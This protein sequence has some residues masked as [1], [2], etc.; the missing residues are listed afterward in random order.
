MIRFSATRVG[1]GVV[2]VL[3]ALFF[4]GLALYFATM[5]VGFESRVEALELE[6][7]RWKRTVP[8]LEDV[9]IVALGKGGPILVEGEAATDADVNLLL[10]KLSTFDRDETAFLVRVWIRGDPVA[11]EASWLPV[12][13]PEVE[14]EQPMDAGGAKNGFMDWNVDI[15]TEL[16]VGSIDR[17]HVIEG[18]IFAS[19]P[20]VEDFATFRDMGVTLVLSNRHE[21]ELHFDERAVV[22]GLGMAYVNVPFSG[23]AQLTDDVIERSLEVLRTSERPVLAHC[24][25]CNRTGAILMA[26]RVINEGVEIERAFE[27][28]VRAGLRSRD[29]ERVVRDY[30][31]RHR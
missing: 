13:S 16:P 21:G 15:L 31:A 27:E 1:V 22:E 6:L 24:Q 28:A 25:A 5:Y 30:I 7:D 9:E 26:H 18:I 14:T 20:A 29:Y 3:G 11:P 4:V 8:G 12:V 23:G 10:E 19:Q 17:C 2:V